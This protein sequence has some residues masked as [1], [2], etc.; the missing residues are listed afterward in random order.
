MTP[1]PESSIDP[2]M[3][4]LIKTAKA[5][6]A[7]RLG[8]SEDDIDVLEAKAMLW[9]DGS[10]GCPQPGMAYIQIPFEGGLIRLDAGGQEYDYHT[11]EGESPFLCVQASK[12]RGR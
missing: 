2:T 4:T 12:E 3:E 8:L 10:L 11:G 7:K 9:P 6:L 1:E 5:D